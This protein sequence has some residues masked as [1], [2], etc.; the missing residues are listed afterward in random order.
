[1]P[2]VLLCY[3]WC[4]KKQLTILGL[5]VVIAIVCTFALSSLST[6]LTDTSS[7][8]TSTATVASTDEEPRWKQIWKGLFVDLV[9]KWFKRA[10]ERTSDAGGSAEQIAV[11]A[12]LL[13]SSTPTNVPLT[14][15][16]PAKLLVN[17]GEETSSRITASGAI[18]NNG[19]SATSHNLESQRSGVYAVAGGIASNNPELI[20]KGL[21]AYEWGF[22]QMDSNGWFPTERAGDAKPMKYKHIHPLSFFL[23]SAARSV[24]MIRAADID[25]S[26]KT[27]AENLIPKLHL[28]A[29][30]MQNA[31]GTP[32]YK[33]N[34]EEF[35]TLGVDTNMLTTPAAAFLQISKLT[36]DKSLA[37]TAKWMV[38]KVLARQAEYTDGTIPE[39]RKDKCFDTDPKCYGFDTTYQ[40]VSLEYLSRYA[41]LVQD[42][43]EKQQV[44][45]A[46]L[47]GTNKFLSKVDATT[48]YIDTSTNSRTVACDERIPGTEPKGK[49]VDII[50][51]R[52]FYIGF[53]LGKS[54][55]YAPIAQKIQ[56]YG[57]GYEH[58][59]QCE[60]PDFSA[61]SE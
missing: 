51:L 60:D 28:A 18:G 27:R 1:M 34:I 23:E 7:D 61:P 2:R 39:K 6:F 29:K 50:P 44:K 59:D 21:R 41:G 35:Y 15:S 38:G 12:T 8:G 16:Y 11:S 49:N 13:S 20:D 52:L 55:T 24:I 36:D 56:E 37:D 26:Y 31:T 10:E 43:I 33:T 3:A 22:A 17:M 54:E 47:L 48:G 32:P 4:M 25:Q 42:P 5:L 30:N 53:L 58:T 40:T 45:D 9:P 14:I 19:L 46:V 57:Q